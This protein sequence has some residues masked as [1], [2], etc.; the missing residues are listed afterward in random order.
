MSDYSEQGAVPVEDAS[1]DEPPTEGEVRDA[2][3][4]KHQELA[5]TTWD[6]EPPPSGREPPSS[7]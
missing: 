3:R 6:R 2:Q 4:R 1:V 7:G 5:E